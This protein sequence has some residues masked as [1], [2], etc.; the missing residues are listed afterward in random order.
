MKYIAA[1]CMVALSGK[2]PSVDSVKKVLESVDA[3]IDNA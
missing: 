2:T 3:K 1:Y